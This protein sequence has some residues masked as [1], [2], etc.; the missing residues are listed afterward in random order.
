MLV[1]LYILRNFG[2]FIKFHN[3]NK[4]FDIMTLDRVYLKKNDFKIK[5][6]DAT[7]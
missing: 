1:K 4:N 2:F 3:K 5:K 7:S 6:S